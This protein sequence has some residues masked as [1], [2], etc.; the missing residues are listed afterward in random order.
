MIGDRVDM[1]R[2]GAFCRQAGKAAYQQ[3]FRS[4]MQINLLL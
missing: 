4:L 1:R 3:V 2:A